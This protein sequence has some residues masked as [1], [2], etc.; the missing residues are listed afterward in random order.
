MSNYLQKAKG[1]LQKAKSSLQKTEGS[2]DEFAIIDRYFKPLY[3]AAPG[4]Q[5]GPGDD[6]AVLAPPAGTEICA[7]TDTLIEGVH[8]PCQVSGRVAAGRALGANLSDLAAMGAEPYALLLALTLPKVRHDWLDDFS[9]TIK[10]LSADYGAPVVGGN[11]ARGD[12]SITVTALG[13]VP[14]GQAIYRNGA[15]AGE[16]IYITGSIGDAGV[17]L[18]LSQGTGVGTDASAVGHPELLA[19]YEQPCPRLATGQGLRGMATAMIDVS[20]GLL[21]DAGHL[22]AASG[23]GGEMD[24]ALVPL[25]DAL[26]QAGVTGAAE[27]ANLGDDYELCFT[28]PVAKA[29]AISQLAAKT[30]VAITKIGETNAGTEL[31]LHKDGKPVQSAGTGYNHFAEPS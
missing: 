9:R 30:G 28:A 18:K 6:S 29:E 19:R 15:S 20:D 26:R 23:I 2:D 27:V 7:T 17:G 31:H 24:L 1:S 14:A 21:A 10:E 16:D 3:A 13:T 25:S 22:L 4:V 11:L 8:L 5:K 12:L